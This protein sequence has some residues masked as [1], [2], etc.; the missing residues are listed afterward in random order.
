MKARSVL[1]ALAVLVVLGLVA[2]VWA[3]GR[4]G[5]K[6]PS[7]RTA[8]VER[9]DVEVQ[10]SAT[11]TLNA[12][13]TVQVG[14]QVSG[15]IAAL[16]VDFNDRV[17]SGQ[18]LA[19]LDPTFLRAQVQEGRANLERAQVE[20]RQAVR[21]SARVF[22]L[23]TKGL[24]SQSE[25]DQSQTAVEAAR[26]GVSSAR[27]ALGRAE[28]NLRYATIL[29]PIDGV[30]VSRD[31]DVGQTVAASLSAPTLFTIAQDLKRM[32]LEAS[33]DEADIG[34]V[35]VGQ[36]ASFTVD[37]YP[38]LSFAGTVHQVRLAP[39]TV[40]NVV[41]YTVIILVENDDEKL[42]PGMTANVTIAVDAARG[43]LRVP[44][45]ALRFRPEGQGGWPGSR[46]GGMGGGPPSG[47]PPMGGA[48]MG[49]AA[50]GGMR[51]DGAHG[52]RGGDRV[53][54]LA[55][56]GSLRPAR[57]RAG[58]SDG[59]FTAVESDSLRE[60]DLVVV[61][62]ETASGAAKQDVVNPFAPRMGGGRGM[63]GGRPR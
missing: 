31:V 60:G 1:A 26:A 4:N 22:P 15:T 14:S 20:L 37:A 17:H 42:L 11:G 3:R 18:V 53:F 55:N 58:L 29:S 47:G 54:L 33:V 5:E 19:Q 21:D 52:G 51:R 25:L 13:T 23:G 43:V 39:E 10:V 28:T 36:Q 45:T 2:M 30:V 44:A 62:R 16:Y 24:A 32:Q 34:Q 63:G 9:G 59:S 41:T 38:S 8:T 49:G 27:A 12:V 61:G 50:M 56:D 46:G 48:P 35:K 57:V 7:Y 6:A 40:Q